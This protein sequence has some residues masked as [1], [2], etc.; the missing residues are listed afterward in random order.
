MQEYIA[1]LQIL[2]PAVASVVAIW[3][4]GSKLKTT[5]CKQLEE[6]RVEFGIHAGISEEKI[7]ELNDIKELLTNVIIKNSL[8]T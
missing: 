3:K 6:I 8:K 5:L 2:V 7:K 1:V 4:I